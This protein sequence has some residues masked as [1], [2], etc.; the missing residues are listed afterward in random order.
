M[1]GVARS[2]PLGVAMS[3]KRRARTRGQN[4][5]VIQYLSYSHLYVHC[6]YTV[7]TCKERFNMCSIYNC[8]CTIFY[9]RY[10]PLSPFLRG[11]GGS[12]GETSG[13]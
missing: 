1:G 2:A 9:V 5:L 13:L 11:I 7:R 10:I 12:G 8:I 4:P 6:C 3:P